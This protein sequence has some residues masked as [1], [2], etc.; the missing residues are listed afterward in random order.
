MNLNLR[1]IKKADAVF[2]IS[3]AVQADVASR[4]GVE[5]KVVYNGIQCDRILTTTHADKGYPFK[6]VQVS[7]LDHTKKGQDLLIEAVG[8]LVASGLDLNIDFI[9]EGQ[10]IGF[11]KSVAQKNSISDR[12]NFLGAKSREYIYKHLCDY[13][14][15]VQPSRE[16]GFGL[17]IAEAMA[18]GVP[19]LVSDISGP[20]EVVGDGEYGTLFKAESVDALADAIRQIYQNYAEYSAKAKKSVE[21]AKSAFDINS[22]ALNYINAYID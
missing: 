10:S 8:D 13:D 1:F 20:K 3:K 19:V 2:S 7:R 4:Y 9:G 5:S 17:T 18:A 22:T 6:I 21:Y 11:L 16:E 15:F 12:V 14:I